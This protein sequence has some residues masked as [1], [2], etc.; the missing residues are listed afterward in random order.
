[1]PGYFNLLYRPYKKCKGHM[2][3]YLLKSLQWLKLKKLFYIN[4]TFITLLGQAKSV[5][6]KPVFFIAP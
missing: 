5:L 4:Y 1:M 6:F 3:L 2:S